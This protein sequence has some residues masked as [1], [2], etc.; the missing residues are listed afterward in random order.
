[1]SN[2]LYDEII[3][4]K[5]KLRLAMK[6]KLDFLSESRIQ[7]SSTVVFQKLVNQTIVQQAKAVFVY[8]SFGFEI[9]TSQ[10]I[11][12][13]WQKNKI[14]L[15]PRIR[16]KKM[17]AIKINSWQNLAKGRFGI[18][19]PHLKLPVWR[20]KIDLTIVPGLAFTKDCWRLGRGGG[21]YDKFLAEHRC[22]SIGLAHA[23]QILNKLPVNKTDIKLN[24]VLIAVNPK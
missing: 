8:L 21:F 10:F 13:C 6:Q 5:Q 17:Q 1:M 23:E 22:Y 2:T 7:K 3:M 12:W 15:A 20:K 4:V 24:A 18:L 9:G 14:V 11:T 19:E 16:N